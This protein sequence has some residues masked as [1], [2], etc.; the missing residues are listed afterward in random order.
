MKKIFFIFGFTL[1]FINNFLP[2]TGSC[3]EKNTETEMK[4]PA[5]SS[6]QTTHEKKDIPKSGDTWTDPVTGMEFVWVSNGCYDMGCNNRPGMCFDDEKPVHEVCVDGFWMGKFEVTNAQYRKFKSDHDSKDFEG[7]SLNGDNQPAVYI[8]WDDAK[9]YI[10]WLNKQ[11]GGHYRFRLPTEAE[12]EYASRAGTKT[13]YYW[14]NSPDDACMYANIGDETSAET[15]N[16]PSAGRMVHVY[17]DDGCGVTSP[18]GSFKPNGFGL[19]DMIG[20]IMEWCED[21]YNK[22]AYGKHERNN[23]VNTSGGS[24]RVVRGGCFWNLGRWFQC[25]SRMR[26]TTS[27]RGDSIGFRLIRAN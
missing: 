14:G 20:N 10:E 18:V 1:I 4:K 25:S 16:D 17:C 27:Y 9:K 5:I 6:W 2:G 22:D 11:N 21:I 19:Y 26:Y 12:W 23:P 8:S 7:E 15:L 24:D 3:I 13:A